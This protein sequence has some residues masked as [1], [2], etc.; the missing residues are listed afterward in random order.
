MSP[1]IE[2]VFQVEKDEKDVQIEFL[3]KDIGKCGAF[4]ASL[5]FASYFQ[6][7]YRISEILQ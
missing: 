5:F 4:D 1:R 6:I 7:F 2:N 3:F